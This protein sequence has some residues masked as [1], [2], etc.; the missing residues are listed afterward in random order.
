MSRRVRLLLTLCKSSLS[1]QRKYPT[2]GAPAVAFSVAISPSG[3]TVYVT[4]LSW[5]PGW[6]YATI[7]Y[8]AATGAQQ[9]IKLYSLPSNG[10]TE[11]QGPVAEAVSPT[12]GTVIVTGAAIT[13]EW[14]TVAYSG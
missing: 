8:N 13:G 10:S 7:A 9:W 3:G 5:K 1:G 6:A 14:A 4:G 12:T 2:I 11:G